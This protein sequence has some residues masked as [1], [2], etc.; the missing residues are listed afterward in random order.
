MPITLPDWE[1]PTV[2]TGPKTLAEAIARVETRG[3]PRVSPPYGGS[4][5]RLPASFWARFEE[6]LS[7]TSA[8]D[9]LDAREWSLI[10]SAHDL[11]YHSGHEIISSDGWAEFIAPLDSEEAGASDVLH[12]AFA[13]LTGMGLD[14][15]E[16][17]EL[18]PYERLVLRVYGYR[19]LLVPGRDA[20]RRTATLV[21]RGMCAAVM[22]LAY[23]GPYD[24]RGRAGFGNYSCS[25]SRGVE[26]GNLYD[27]FVTT[28]VVS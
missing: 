18:V 11:G 13:A 25:Q 3:C 16:I 5:D 2:A 14:D 7:G 15:C 20:S 9:D 23:A 19:G 12:A 24:S 17:A 26:R 1:S 6:S 28:R 8:E 21:V 10:H 27:E 22:D 4:L